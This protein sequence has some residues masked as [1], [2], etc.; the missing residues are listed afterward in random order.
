[1]CEEEEEEEEAERCKLEIK[2]FE[3]WRAENTTMVAKATDRIR[4]D[5]NS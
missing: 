4:A 1:M 5:R 2:P 3:S